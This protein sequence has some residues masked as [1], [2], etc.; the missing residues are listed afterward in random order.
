[1]TN[2]TAAKQQI[3]QTEDMVF[4]IIKGEVGDQTK[5][6]E[7]VRKAM[8]IGIITHVL[9]EVGTVM[10]SD[11]YEA[12]LVKRDDDGYTSGQFETFTRTLGNMQNFFFEDCT[13]EDLETAGL[14]LTGYF[15]AA[16]FNREHLKNGTFFFHYTENIAQAFRSIDE[17]DDTEIR[18]AFEA[19]QVPFIDCAWP[20]VGLGEMKAEA[21]AMI[22]AIIAQHAA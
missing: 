13:D 11:R 12:L 10:D 4:Q 14:F 3:Q 17:N 9:N 1:M 22:A 15:E 6:T 8:V 16:Q 21:E 7:G 5:I 19:V 2:F 18:A 20:S